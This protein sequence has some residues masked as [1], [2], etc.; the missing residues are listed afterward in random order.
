MANV[1][2]SQLP[3]APSAITG[4]ELVPVVQNGQTVQTTVN[5]L[6]SSP[7]LTQT[8]LTKNQEPTLPN[9]RYV[10]VG[11]GLSITDAGAQNL[12]Q[13]SP[14]GALASLVTSSVGIQVK[15]DA[16]TLT[17]RSIAT[18]G[19][20][21]SISNGSGVSGDP[22]LALSGLPAA[23]ANTVGTGL[24]A[25]SASTT[26]TP[27]SIT[28]ESNEIT[29]A[30]G[31]AAGGSNPLI[32]LA[33]NPILPGTG[34]TTLPKGTTGQRPANSAGQLRF[35]TTNNVFEGQDSSG[36]WQVLAL[37]GG[38]TSITLGTGLTGSPN[39]I[40]ST[41]TI[42]LANTVVTP[43]TY[44][45]AS[46]VG[47][48]TVDQ[49]GRLTAAANV[50]ITA[51]GIGAI[52]AVNGT[53]NEITTSQVGTVVTASL[54][55]A[56][57]F[58]G[59]TVTGGTFNATAATVGGDTVTT[60]TA[61]QTLTGKTISGANN[62]LSNIGNGS[63]TN[64]QITLG[65]TNVALGGTALTLGGITTITVT[66]DPVSNFQL[67]TKQYVDTLVSSGIHFHTPVRV[68]SPTNLNATYNQPG[69]AGDG[70]GATLTNAGTQ[71]ALVID[72]VTV[73]VNDRV[74]IYTQTTQTQNGVYV[75]TDVGSGSTN[76]VL[77][78]S[79]DTNTYGL[80]SSST[81]GEGSTFFVQQGTTGAGETY[82]CNTQGV[83]VFGT[84]NITFAQISAT[85]IYS[86]GTGLSLTGTTFSIANTAVTAGA[87]GSASSVGT[88][89]VNA[90]GQLT[91]AA[92]T[93]ISIAASQINTTIPN[94]GLT[95]SSITINGS[96]ISLGGSVSVG[97]VTSITSSTL[98]V[99]GTSAVP[100]IDLTSGIVTA[101]TTG[102]STQVPVVT[103]DTY[104]RVTNITTAAIGG[105][106]VT[107]VSGTGTVSGI[108]LSGTVT[109]SGSLTLGGALD[110]SSPPAIGGTTPAAI[111]GTT[112]TASN[113]VGVSGGT[114]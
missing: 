75:V 14:A 109:S 19:N 80:T 20:G 102:S 24:L 36:T 108:T 104:G 98:T 42:D 32:G 50:N 106:T 5:A 2:I 105:G 41:G 43:G 60:N 101:G 44:G 86:A 30:N 55:S 100:T 88:F 107:S 114:F 37:G 97:T 35:N 111:T 84:T 11:A 57:T 87:Y 34:A 85:Q 99:G 95:N 4:S 23:L 65:T 7:S 79:T 1:R 59:K 39:P 52:S 69:G 49:Q 47:Q 93:A 72:G 81:L 13:I 22:T 28:G 15:T 70:V 40:T 82:T 91:L 89:T 83:I 62:T 113:Y 25:V 112:I 56:L 26:L 48:F 27:V 51:S 16:T 29:V 94:S 46:Q 103:V 6:V 12:L 3:A 90:Q 78:R 9:S 77:T 67:A 58:T 38:V 61:T 33:D 74:L 54:P 45:S 10:G 76:W 64:S 73:A 53:A 18:S 17:N 68:E 71:A 21:L 92:T 8:F 63:L 66:Q 31:N 96:T 110:L